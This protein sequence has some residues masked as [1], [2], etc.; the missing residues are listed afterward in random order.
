V[1][2]LIGA[3]IFQGIRQIGNHSSWVEFMHSWLATWTAC[4]V[5]LGCTR[6]VVAVDFISIDSTA[7][8]ARRP[9]DSFLLL[10]ILVAVSGL[11]SVSFA[12][13][14]VPS[15]FSVFQRCGGFRSEC[16]TGG[17]GDYTTYE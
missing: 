2:F 14:S 17:L 13:Q 12:P 4:G 11:A 10:T 9:S 7:G 16:G 8:V 1:R 6:L 3:W 15:T 5:I